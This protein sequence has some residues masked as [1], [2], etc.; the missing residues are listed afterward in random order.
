VSISDELQPLIESL[1]QSQKYAASYF[2]Y[3]YYKLFLR[4]DS[5][6]FNDIGITYNVIKKSW[7]IQYGLSV[8]SASVK[9]LNGY[10]TLVGSAHENTVYVE[11][12]AIRSFD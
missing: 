12:P 10:K 1:P 3:P 8:L 5:S 6:S 4:S 7:G 2:A 9:Y 11:E